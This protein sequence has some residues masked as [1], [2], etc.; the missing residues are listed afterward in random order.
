MKFV[1][2]TSM[3][4]MILVTIFIYGSY[5]L[6]GTLCIKKKLCFFVVCTS[7]IYIE[8]STRAC[9][10]DWIEGG[11]SLSFEEDWGATGLLELG[12]GL[13]DGGIEV[14]V[15]LG[16]G[17]TMLH[18]VHALHRVELLCRWEHVVDGHDCI[19]C[20]G[21][22]GMIVE[23]NKDIAPLPVF[24][25]EGCGIWFALPQGGAKEMEE[26]MLFG[27]IHYWELRWVRSLRLG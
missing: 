22:E 18:E 25:L 8:I 15:G 14:I 12:E 21:K 6:W 20:K 13:D 5:L 19:G 24:G 23:G 26:D 2:D 17:G 7:Y 3:F 4:D 1:S 10:L 9:I 16:Y 11:K 27:V